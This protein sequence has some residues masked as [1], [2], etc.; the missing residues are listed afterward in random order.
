MKEKYEIVI[1]G[2]GPAGATLARELSLKKRDVLLI[3][4]GKDWRNSPFYGTYIGCL[5]YIDKSGFLFTKEGLN[6]IRGILTGGST[7]LYCGTASPPPEWLKNKYKID[8]ENYVNETIKELNI[9]PLPPE[10]IGKASQRCLEAAN[11]LG[12]KWELLPKFMD[13]SKCKYGFTCGARCM[14]GCRCG[15]KWTANEYI[16]EAKKYGC[17]ILTSAEVEKVLIYDKQAV[18]IK[19]KIFGKIPF[20]LEA[21]IVVLSAGGLGTP[22]ILQNSGLISAGKGILMDPTVMVYGVYKEEGT[23]N[24]P[25]MA[26]GS[27]DDSNGYILS[28]LIDPYLLF[29]IIMG[30]N[31]LRQSLKVVNYKKMLGIMIKVKDQISGYLTRDGEISKP[32]TK[33]DHKKLKHAIEISRRILLRAGCDKNSFLVTPVRGTHPSGTVRIGELLDTNLET[34]IKN[35]FVCDASVFPE[36]LDRPMVLTIIGLAKYLANRIMKKF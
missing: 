17:E 13:I 3:E 1:V 18:G 10:L 34:Y 28:H 12:L 29:P 30:F 24:C 23:Y 9:K 5:F 36:A 8:I 26:V 16:D 32:L 19:G 2:S 15:A 27:Y 25:P 35:L 6:I 22:I 14:L 4:K 21:D 7:N 20:E 33:E 11:E 31:G